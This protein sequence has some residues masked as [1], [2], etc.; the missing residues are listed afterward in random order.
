MQKEVAVREALLEANAGRAERE[1]GVKKAASS[2]RESNALWRAT[3]Q[4]APRRARKRR[5]SL[6][7]WR[8]EP[9]IQGSDVEAAARASLR[10]MTTAGERKCCQHQAV[11]ATVPQ[12]SVVAIV[13]L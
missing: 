12:Q 9:V 1:N 6:S 3:A 7:R 4:R 8:A 11:A 13:L 10:A 5:P 2:R